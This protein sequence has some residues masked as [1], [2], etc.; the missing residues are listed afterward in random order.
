VI[1]MGEWGSG[2]SPDSPGPAWRVN[3][4]REVDGSR[5]ATMAK[6]TGG[7]NVAFRSAKGVFS[8]RAKGDTGGAILNCERY[9]PAPPCL[10]QAT[11]PEQAFT[12][13]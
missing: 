6:E 13:R 8:R 12:S 4:V 11:I 1:R 9:R 2:Q 3:R 10:T 7:S 5:T